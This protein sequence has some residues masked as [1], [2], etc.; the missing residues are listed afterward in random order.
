MSLLPV[1]A[2]EGEI[3]QRTGNPGPDTTMRRHFIVRVIQVSI[4]ETASSHRTG[5]RG[6]DRGRVCT[7]DHDRPKRECEFGGK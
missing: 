6:R 7:M 5:E 3:Y 4:C 2:P 1:D